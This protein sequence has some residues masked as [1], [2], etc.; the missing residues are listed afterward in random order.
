VTDDARLVCLSRSNGKARWIAQLQ[1]FDN[2][3]KK[4]GPVT[5]YGPVLA[6]ERLL[7]TNSRGEI[8]S[9]NPGDGKVANTIETKTPF[10]L[11]PI[12]ANST[13]YTLDQKGKITAYR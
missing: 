8:V 6:G 13:L 9:V 7:L 11:P 2:E 4:K 1:R 10:T 12:V 5:W 3:K